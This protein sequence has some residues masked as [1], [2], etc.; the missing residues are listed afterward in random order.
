MQAPEQI[1]QID[2]ARKL[3]DVR[4]AGFVTAEDAG[5]M[6]EEVRAAILSLDAEP[7]THVTL[8][9]VTGLSVAPQETIEAVKSMFANPEVRPLWARKVAIVTKSALGKMQFRRLREARG[10]IAIFTERDEAI[11]WLFA[12]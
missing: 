7:E 3:I 6:G 2:Y 8:Y 1:I 11:E 10:D 4:I 9:D 12:A 5:W